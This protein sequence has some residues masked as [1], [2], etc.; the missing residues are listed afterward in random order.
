PMVI[1]RSPPLLICRSRLR[2]SLRRAQAPSADR[3][4]RRKMMGE[5]SQRAPASGS[6]RVGIGYDVHPLGSGRPLILGGVTVPHPRGLEGHSD[7][8]VLSHAIA[9]ALIGAAGRGDLGQWFPDSDD[10]YLGA[11]SLGLLRQ[12]AAAL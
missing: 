12:V 1:S 8:D 6:F 9:D 2:C 10:Q 4:M 5:P 3:R 11:E 7:G